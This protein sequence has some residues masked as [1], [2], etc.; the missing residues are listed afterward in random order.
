MNTTKL[1]NAIMLFAAAF[2]WGTAF[3]FQSKANDYMQPFTF[4]AARC[5]V[6]AM[7]LLPFIIFKYKK[8]SSKKKTNASIKNSIIAGVCCGVALTIASVLQQYGVKYTSVGKAGFITTLYIIFTP[9]LGI[10]IKKKCPWTVWISSISAAIGLYLLCVT[11]DFFLS[12]GDML[13]LICAVLFSVHILVIDYF[14]DK[15]DGLIVA[16]VQLFICFIISGVL[17]FGFDKPSFEQLQN[18]TI[19]ILYAGIMSSGVAY[20]LQVLG[21]KNFNPTAAAIILSLES[22]VS[23]IAGYVAYYLGFLNTDQSLSGI[24]IIGCIIVF[25]SVIFVQL[26]IDKLFTKK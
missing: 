3:V 20:T 17:A 10:F 15:T 21:Q 26:P 13:V 9:I 25:V 22:V 1:K 4:S 24:Q 16:C 18:G 2:I 14:S 19:P 12:E 11:E 23:A 7:V 8:T 5:I 6:G